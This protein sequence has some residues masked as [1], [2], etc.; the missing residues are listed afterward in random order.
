MKMLL[1]VVKAVVAVAVAVGV[2]VVVAQVVTSVETLAG[3]VGEMHQR[4]SEAALAAY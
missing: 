2:A 4:I 3:S 1:V